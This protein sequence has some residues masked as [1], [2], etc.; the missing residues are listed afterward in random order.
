M[1]HLTQSWLLEYI[2]LCIDCMT[3]WQLYVILWYFV[4][5][6]VIPTMC[7]HVRWKSNNRLKFLTKFSIDCYSF[8]WRSCK[9]TILALSAF[10]RCSMTIGYRFS[11]Q[12]DCFASNNF[13]IQESLSYYTCLDYFN[14]I[15]NLDQ[16]IQLLKLDT[17]LLK[18]NTNH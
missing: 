12:F 6:K 11:Y 8:K 5:L 13:M 17:K 9:C 3:S 4:M 1:V 15:I 16:S 14:I 18:S 2:T 10:Y 7:H